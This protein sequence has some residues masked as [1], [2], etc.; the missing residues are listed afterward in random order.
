MTLGIRDL[1]NLILAAAWR[2]R[3]LILAPIVLFSL[4]SVVAALVW[5]RMY[6][7]RTLL[8]LQERQAS[9]PLSSGGPVR[10]GRVRVD[11]ID[12]LMKSDRVLTSAILDFN[13]GKPPLSAAE[14]E[15]AVKSLRRQLSV[16]V[17]GSE[18]IEI[19]LRQSDRQ[20]LGSRL[21]VLLT[22]FF[23]RLLSRE[24]SMK[25]ARQFAL[26]QR[27]R[28]MDI[29]RA[30]IEDWLKR[31]QLA[32]ARVNP[33]DSRVPELQAKFSALEQR[34]M[35][36]AS[37]LLSEPITPATLSEAIADEIRLAQARPARQSAGMLPTSSAQM[38]ALREL[39][40]EHE[41]YLA[42]GAD[43]G[44][45]VLASARVVA[46]SLPQAQSGPA[47]AI[48]QEWLSLDARFN[49]A[50]TQY[51][52]H[53]KR[54]RKA[55]GPT[56]TPFGLIAPESIRIIDE[57]RDPTLPTTSLLKIILACLVGGI[58][59]GVSLAAIA[60]QLDD[61]VYEG[62]GLEGIAGAENV[63][64][65]PHIE[66]DRNLADDLRDRPLRRLKHLSVVSEG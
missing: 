41:A 63:F 22:R 60:E 26:E 34:L 13:V 5:P 36:V 59:L 37:S 47:Q 49:E 33:A 3:R 29:S 65:I 62:R 48:Y 44:K 24:D 20:G 52:A 64:R 23:E 12:T 8:M 43:L 51:D 21:S 16:S 14:L 55:S 35:V 56:L 30:A 1:I 2:R 53:Q 42:V 25:T 40:A 46:Q 7:A 17:V 10:E 50:M 18:F 66:G 9:D 45:A 31:A 27:R 4:L 28:D 38:N 15:S 6:T 58:G 39:E 11:E 57:P 61:R 32:G 19:E 54:S